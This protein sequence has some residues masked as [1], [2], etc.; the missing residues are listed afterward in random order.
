MRKKEPE[1][2]F[3]D[4]LHINEFITC[5]TVN[6]EEIPRLRFTN[7]D[8]WAKDGEGQIWTLDLEHDIDN[9]L[10]YLTEDVCKGLLKMFKRLRE[11]K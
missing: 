2:S 6:G 1:I 11:E 9:K 3:V 7:T 10:T 4:Q 8:I 5:M